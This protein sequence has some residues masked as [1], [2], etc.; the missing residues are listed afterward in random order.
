MEWVQR[1]KVAKWIIKTSRYESKLQKMKKKTIISIIEKG[2]P[3]LGWRVRIQNINL[4]HLLYIE[5]LLLSYFRVQLNW[6]TSSVY[7]TW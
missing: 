3:R 5:I 4:P 1:S 7:I 6:S 2:V